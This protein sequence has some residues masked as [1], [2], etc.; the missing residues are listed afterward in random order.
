M[1]SS[2]S[3]YYIAKQGINVSRA[4]LEITGQNI[5]NVNTEGYTR[6]RVDTYA[7]GSVAGKSIYAAAKSDYLGN[8]AFVQE[9][10][11]S[12]DPYLDL[13]YRQENSKFG[14]A[15]AKIEVL[16][17]V[18]YVLDS[19]TIDGLNDQMDELISHLQ[20]L[21]NQANDPVVQGVVKSSAKA[22]TQLLNQFAGQIE[23][24]KTE[25]VSTVSDAALREIN[26]YLKNIATLNREIKSSHISGDP[27][28]E[29]M[30]QRNVLIDNLSTYMN[31]RTST[32]LVDV[33]GGVMVEELS[34]DMK[35]ANGDAFHL[36]NDGE[37]AQFGSYVSGD[38]VRV[39]LFN[40]EGNPES[41]SENGSIALTNGD[42]TDY[43]S[44]GALRGYID[45][46]N[47]AGQFDNPPTN[48]KGIVYYEKMLDTFAYKH[49]EVFN[50]INS[51]DTEYK[52]MFESSV[53]GEE[54]KASN[55]QISKAW[56]DFEG[57][58][59]TSTKVQPQ[60]GVD[61]S[62]DN[63]NILNMISVFEQ[64]H[65]FYNEDGIFAFNGT[66]D[67]F[68]TELST[69]LGLDIQN[70]TQEKSVYEAGLSEIETNRM[71]VSGVS[72]DEEAI[73]MLMYNRSF[74]ASSRFMTTIDE[75]IET[76]INKMGLAGR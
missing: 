33:G 59:L 27:A 5:S 47:S 25:M 66:F 75:I 73:D 1:R 24:S 12:R 49:A 23:T 54:V 38:D 48:K 34:I 40:F 63:S 41:Y 8:G 2:F 31:I 18:G 39:Q 14:E 62:T 56:E 65:D 50:S 76:I 43:L 20:S 61:I 51:T 4:Q 44:A 7:L 21:S 28:L 6:Q 15:S 46:I 26:G 10:S 37:F 52:P 67:A 29:L 35:T 22:L 60:P 57:A 74:S 45:G 9:Y 64:K 11:Q 58:Y 30:D 13:R 16:N 19:A 70:T 36:I 72:V 42:M 71:S 55:I 3:G 53:A 17:E 68:S 69:V 32:K